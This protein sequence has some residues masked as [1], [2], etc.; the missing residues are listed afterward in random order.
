MPFIHPEDAF[1]S[2]KEYKP[3]L[4]KKYRG[5]Q[6]CK[7]DNFLNLIIHH[8]SYERYGYEKVSDLRLL[9]TLCHNEFHKKVSGSDYDL[10]YLTDMF[11][12]K[13]GIWM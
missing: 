6:A 9:C 1:M 11:I 2:Y 3:L 12:K 5:C 8:V 7:D 10:K 13:Q 4:Y